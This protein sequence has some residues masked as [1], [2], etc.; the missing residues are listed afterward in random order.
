MHAYTYFDLKHIIRCNFD[1]LT[2]WE[3]KRKK[4]QI[5]NRNNKWKMITLREMIEDAKKI[6]KYMMS[7][8]NNV[9]NPA[10]ERLAR[11][12]AAPRENQCIKINS[13]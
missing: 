5:P 3:K 4:N 2:K 11:K 7:N 6:N 12:H 9:L 1:L 13:R 8:N 10:R